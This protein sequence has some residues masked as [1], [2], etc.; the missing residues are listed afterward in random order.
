MLVSCRTTRILLEAAEREGV[1]VDELLG[2]IQLE[3]ANV[4]EPGRALH[5]SDVVK[6]F[7]RLSALVGDDPQRLRA[8]GR[9][10]NHVG[11]YAAIRWIARSAASPAALYRFADRWIA[12]ANFPH[13]PLFVKTA[14]RDRLLVHGAIPEPHA[15]SKPFFEVM[16]GNISELPVLMGLEPSRV[17]DARVE[18]R[19]LDLELALP[20]DRSL[21]SRAARR[22]LSVVRSKNDVRVLED[23]RS[24]LA[25]GLE[26][27]QRTRDELRVLLWRLPDLVLIHTGGK[28]VFVNRAL[29]TALGWGDASELAGA[30]I[31]AIVDPCSRALFADA[32]GAFADESSCAE[33]AQAWLRSRRGSR[34]LVEIAQAADVVFNGVPARLV[35]GRDLRERERLHQQLA[36]ADRLASVGLL[37]AGVAHEINNPLA[38]VL[39]NIEVARS[40]LASLERPAASTAR[41]AL[42]IALEG[43][44]RIRF[45]V[46]ELLLLARG[47]DGAVGPTDV[48]SVVESTVALARREIERTAKLVLDFQPVPHARARVASL[49]Q[50]VLNL[51]LNA[52]EAMRSRRREDNELT[53]RV[54]READ[55]RVV[56]EVSDNG[57][58]VAAEDL[59]R[60][61]EP[62]YTTKPPGK[63][64]GLG[65]AITQRLVLELGGEISVIS[66]RD[67]GSTFRVLLPVAGDDQ[68]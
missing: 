31:D 4:S 28:I 22:V 15:P 25:E 6:L 7:A 11:S 21:V 29:V 50:I 24:A 35:V 60:V 58:G 1:D 61:F 67:A 56:V 39:N 19:S 65:L 33:L 37:A 49:S 23:Q 63:G 48:R 55:G 2:P 13:L 36:A 16:I 68:D 41:E 46:R 20:P 51:L 12:P 5:W 27:I 44:D 45:I 42:G 43:V 32:A 40:Q 52:I 47:D 57:V 59:L 26:G 3:R 14:S 54:R 9:A 38:Y 64:T 8:L 53:V 10:T 18:P 17:L 34:V 62:F 30:S 66:A